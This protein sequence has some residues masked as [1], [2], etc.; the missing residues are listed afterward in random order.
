MPRFRD[1]AIST[2]VLLALFGMLVAVSGSVRDRVSQFV[3]GSGDQWLGPWRFVSGLMASQSA[4]ALGY[5]ANNS[6]QV[7][8]VVIAGL[9]LILMLRA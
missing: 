2:A 8:F 7:F 9:L 1:A 3:G 4:S 5:A 6:Y